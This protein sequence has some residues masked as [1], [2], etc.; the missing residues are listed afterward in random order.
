MENLRQKKILPGCKVKTCNTHGEYK[1]KE[2]TIPLITDR[3]YWTACPECAKIE[4]AKADAYEKKEKEFERKRLLTFCGIPKRFRESTFNNYKL[5]NKKA[6]SNLKTIKAYCSKFKTV[7]KKGSSL[8]CCGTPGTGKTHIAC[9]M[10]MF[11]LSKKNTVTYTTSYKMMARIKATYSKN[12]IESEAE[13]LK[14]LI[15]V[16]LLIIDE[17]GVQFGSK[18]DSVLFYQIINGRY[19]NMLPTVLISNL[20]KKELA[21]SIGERCFDRLKEGSGVVLSFDWESYRK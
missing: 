19:D 11:I 1:S 15:N 12:S 16:D 14:R 8:I 3:S 20:T 17:I 4:Q 18:A 10:G 9:A 21:E 13:V 7:L 5:V 6:E 2:Y